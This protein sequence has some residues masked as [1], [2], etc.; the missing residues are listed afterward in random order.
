MLCRTSRIFHASAGFSLRTPL[1]V[2]SFS[3]KAFGFSCDGQPEIHRVIEASREFITRT[4]L[5]SAYDLYYEYIPAPE[6]VGLTVDLMFVDSGGYEVSEARDLSAV[7]KPVH[8]PKD[9]DLQKL[10]HIAECWPEAFPAVFISYDHPNHRC[11]VSE[12][13]Q[14]AKEFLHRH[15]N[16][17]HSF[18]LKPES[19]KESTLGPALQTLNEHIGELTGFH[20]FGVTDKELGSSVLERMT[21]IARLR[22]ALDAA[23]LSIPIHVLGALDPL[24]VALYFVAG[25]EVFDGL[26]WVRYAY[27]SG[28]CVYIQNNAALNYGIDMP[29]D[30]LR[31]RTIADNLRCLEQLER[32]LRRLAET[33]DWNML[34]IHRDF[35]RQAAERLHSELGRA[36]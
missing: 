33:K 32:T 15:D 29:G 35:V 16:H 17:L 20:L 12:Q 14:S 34:T 6:D 21:R 23:G 24:S 7:D 3:S 5:I 18:L 25:A 28:Q 8:K 31:V 9:W 11:P 36:E 10:H 22:L 19:P 2:P 27:S 30:E 26:T 13:I 4:C 1:L